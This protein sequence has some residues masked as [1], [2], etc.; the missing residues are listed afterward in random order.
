MTTNGPDA[1]QTQDW[2]DGIID[3]AVGSFLYLRFLG[4]ANRGVTV[5]GGSGN[6]WE[7]IDTFDHGRYALSY[8]KSLANIRTDRTDHQVG[9]YEFSD[10]SERVIKL[11]MEL[12]PA[13]FGGLHSQY[14]EVTI[15][16]EPSAPDMLVSDCM[17]ALHGESNTHA[18]SEAT[19]AIMDMAT[20]DLCRLGEL[21]LEIESG[22]EKADRSVLSF[23]QLVRRAYADRP[24]ARERI[25]NMPER[26]RSI[27]SK[28]ISD[29]LSDRGNE[30]A[31]VIAEALNYRH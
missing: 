26:D 25:A 1:E 22:D 12:F 20:A 30:A 29:A 10:T 14:A 3:D 11:H 17:R 2:I 31:S 9:C 8:L 16:T 7:H 28:Q 23:G 15:R 24:A 13:V 27:L 4:K 19:G 6:G 5:F 21:L 18:Q